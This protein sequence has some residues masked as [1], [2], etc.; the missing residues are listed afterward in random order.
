MTNKKNIPFSPPHVSEAIINEVTDT[1]RSGWWTTGPKT[2]LFEKKIAEYSQVPRAICLNSATAGLE[3]ILRWFGVK[4]GDEVIIPAYTYSATANVV[5]HCGATPVMVDTGK[6]FNIDPQKIEEAITTKTKVII[7]VD[8]AG[9]PCDYQQIREIIEQKKHLF[10]PTHENQ[11]KLGRILLMA[12]AAHSFG[13]EYQNKKAATFSDIAVFSFHA[14]KNLP[15]AEGGAVCIN[16][17]EP[18]DAEDVYKY[19]NIMSLHGQTKDALAKTQGSNWEY[20]II[21]PGYKANMTDIQASIGLAQL[22]EYP[23][24]LQR[25]KE[26]FLQYQA[27]FS[28]YSRVELP[29]FITPEKISSFHL[30]LLRINNISE[31][32]RNRIIDEIFERNVSVNVHFKPL[33][34]LSA[35]K[36]AG[37]DINNYPV[38]YDNFSRVISLPVYYDLT[39]EQVQRVIHAVMESI[40]SVLQNA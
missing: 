38:A 35:Y 18:F 40:E 20:D 15:T 29:P 34:L 28:N 39:D 3:L 19:L 11:K 36:N 30:F 21:F 31:Q 7:P 17:P 12:D 27:A 6:D 8:I 23:K 22:P 9:F 2:K 13:A 14:V 16:L 10:T 1:L 26:I 24:M 32:E 37:Y 25:R 33:P 5:M 4:E